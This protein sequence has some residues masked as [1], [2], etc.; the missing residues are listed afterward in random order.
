M[1]KY[2]DSTWQFLFPCGYTVHHNVPMWFSVVCLSVCVL[3]H[4]GGQRTYLTL[5]ATHHSTW[6]SSMTTLSVS[7]CCSFTELTC[8]SVR[9]V[10]AWKVYLLPPIPKREPSQCL[11]RHTYANPAK[12]RATSVPSVEKWEC[13]YMSLKLGIYITG[14]AFCMVHVSRHWDGCKGKLSYLVDCL[15]RWQKCCSLQRIIKGTLH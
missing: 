7:S 11:Y 13:M 14:T 2:Y 8:T 9:H 6:Q 1:F 5:R 10:V 12:S 15:S 3:C 4:A